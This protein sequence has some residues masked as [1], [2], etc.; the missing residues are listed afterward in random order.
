[1]HQGCRGVGY[2]WA[3]RTACGRAAGDACDGQV[4]N[5]W[6]GEDGV[7]SRVRAGV[8]QHDGVG[9]RAAYRDWAGWGLGFQCCGVGHRV[10]DRA[11]ARDAAYAQGCRLTCV[12]NGVNRGRVAD[13]EAGHA[14]RYGDVACGQ[15]HAVAEHRRVGEVGAGC[16]GGAG[17]AEGV[18]RWLGRRCA[19]GDGLY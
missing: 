5:D 10:V 13:R 11:H 15:G 4:S 9:D 2:G 18:G 19:Q 8:A 12:C 3:N 1:M 6:V 17:Q 14:G 16:R 7:V